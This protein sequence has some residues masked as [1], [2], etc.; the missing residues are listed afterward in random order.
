MHEVVTARDQQLTKPLAND[1]IAKPGRIVV[2]AEEVSA[3]AN[4][5][6]VI[7]SPQVKELGSSSLCFFILYRNISPGKWTPVY[8][9]E[10]KKPA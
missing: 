6:M 10:I 3:T 5:E 8:K 1:K 4:A 9:S 7:F 2:T